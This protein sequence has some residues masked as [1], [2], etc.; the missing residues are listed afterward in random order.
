MALVHG[1]S[2]W[3]HPY[4]HCYDH[5]NVKHTPCVTTFRLLRRRRGEAREAWEGLEKPRSNPDTDALTNNVNESVGAQLPNE[6]QFP[7]NTASSESQ[8]RP[9]ALMSSGIGE[10]GRSEV[11]EDLRLDGGLE[12]AKEAAMAKEAQAREAQARFPCYP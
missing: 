2:H 10:G 8:R 4:T 7:R 11:P 12:K 6:A 1:K 5:L 3:H 9:P